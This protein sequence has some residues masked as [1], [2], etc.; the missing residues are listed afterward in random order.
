MTF[1]I[2][3]SRS[4]LNHWLF[5][6]GSPAMQFVVHQLNIIRED[7]SDISESFLVNTIMWTV[8][9]VYFLFFFF[10]HSGVQVHYCISSVMT[11]DGKN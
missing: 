9:R 2:Y 4:V 3:S 10:V 8:A 7:M 11:M 5:T 1:I 6:V